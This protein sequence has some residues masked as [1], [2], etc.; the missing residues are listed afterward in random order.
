MSSAPVVQF[1]HI[2][3]EIRVGGVNNRHTVCYFSDDKSIENGGSNLAI[4]LK[5]GEYWSYVTEKDAILK[6]RG[7]IV[8]LVG[9]GAK[10]SD[11]IQTLDGVNVV[12]ITDVITELINVGANI[13]IDT[14]CAP[15]C[16]LSQV[17][18]LKL[19]VT[20]YCIGDSTGETKVLYKNVDAWW[21]KHK[22]YKAHVHT[23]SPTPVTTL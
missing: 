9:H 17:K 12:K 3:S 14:C 4:A 18:K 15:E 6:Y 23:P 11:Y 8:W 19:N 22:F 20:Y 21:F 1:K 5:E 7:G 13:I 16:R 10:D 2:P